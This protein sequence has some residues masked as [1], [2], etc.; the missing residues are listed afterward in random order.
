ME[1]RE[2]NDPSHLTTQ[3][4]FARWRS[5]SREEVF[6]PTGSLM[7]SGSL[8]R[9]VSAIGL[10][11]QSRRSVVLAAELERGGEHD[12]ESCAKL[13]SDQPADPAPTRA[14]PKPKRGHDYC[15]AQENDQH[16]FVSC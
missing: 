1:G 5:T 4:L 15:A 16:A 11:G 2:H 12:P 3:G 9:L 14:D 7:R 10:R 13:S 6:V 8:M